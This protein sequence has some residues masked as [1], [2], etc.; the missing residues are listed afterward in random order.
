MGF[1]PYLLNASLIIISG[2]GFRRNAH[3]VDTSIQDRI[4]NLQGRLVTL[5]QLLDEEGLD[6]TIYEMLTKEISPNLA[7]DQ[8]S[9]FIRLVEELVVERCSHEVLMYLNFNSRRYFAY[10][11]G[12]IRRQIE[13]AETRA[14]KLE[15]LRHE[16]KAVN[17][18]PCEFD[19]A[20]STKYPSLQQMI[21]DWL[22]E[23]I[24]FLERTGDT[25][26]TL[27]D[28][29]AVKKDFKLEFDMSVSQFAFFIKS[30]IETG[31]IQ[32]KNVSELIRFLARFVKT[33]RS[34]NISYDSFR[35]KYYNV[36]GGTKDVVKNTLHNAIGYINRN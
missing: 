32:N 12:S 29:E 13:L 27:L 14:E 19:I 10:L 5:K 18:V 26:A 23:E 17:Q 2:Y 1:L 20:Y 15:R 30:F 33:K 6:V 34:E 31:V 4:K 16:L 8:L 28:K 7:K 36:E 22:N 25:T 35:M 3:I 9:Y 21:G 24:Q 11:T